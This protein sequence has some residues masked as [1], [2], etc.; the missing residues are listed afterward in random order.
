[1]LCSK[2]CDD[3]EAV[4]AMQCCHYDIAAHCILL[5]GLDCLVSCACK[6]KSHCVRGGVVLA[7]NDLLN[8]VLRHSDALANAYRGC[9][10]VRIGTSLG[11]PFRDYPGA[12]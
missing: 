3:C 9:H 8:N 11:L 6:C 10:A 7:W 1:M 5:E 12:R 4:R 2:L